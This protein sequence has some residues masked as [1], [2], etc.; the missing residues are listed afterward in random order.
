MDQFDN[1]LSHILISWTASNRSR[2][3]RCHRFAED[4]AYVSGEGIV[5]GYN[6]GSFRPDA[7]MTRGENG[8]AG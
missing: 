3:Q 4:I 6:D 7:Q 1:G 8:A 5:N 2:N